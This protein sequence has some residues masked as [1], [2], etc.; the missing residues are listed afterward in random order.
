MLLHL[1]VEET[2]SGQAQVVLQASGCTQPSR[3]VWAREGRPLAPRGGGRLHLSQDGR[4]LL[5]S[6]FSLEWDLGNYSVLCSGVLG[7]GGDQITL[8]GEPQP[9]K[10]PDFQVPEGLP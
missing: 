4:R 6:N 2:R 3:A 5:I 7:A 1:L 10:S 8:I 9:S